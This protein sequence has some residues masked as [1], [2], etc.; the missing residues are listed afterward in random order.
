MQESFGEQWERKTIF[1]VIKLFRITIVPN[2]KLL[3]TL[4]IF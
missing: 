4:F 2:K 3:A 1:D